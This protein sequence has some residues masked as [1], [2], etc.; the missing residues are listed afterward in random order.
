[1]RTG[2]DAGRQKIM[3]W[4]SSF[5]CTSF[6]SCPIAHLIASS[7]SMAIVNSVGS[8]EG[9]SRA[10]DAAPRRLGP[11]PP[12]CARPAEMGRAT[13]DPE[14]RS[15]RCADHR[16]DGIADLPYSANDTM[17]SRF[18]KNVLGNRRPAGLLSALALVHWGTAERALRAE[19]CRCASSSI[20]DV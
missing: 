12:F 16:R 1:M 6:P 15:R 2:W 17:S 14:R 11:H 19:T 9:L 3:V 5:T 4:L 8:G 18:P 13:V 20:R 10:F 7:R